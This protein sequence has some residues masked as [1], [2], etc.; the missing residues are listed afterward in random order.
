MMPRYNKT[1]TAIAFFVINFLYLMF[2]DLNE[3]AIKIL[4]HQTIAVNCFALCLWW[5]EKCAKWT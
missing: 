1:W 5:Q 4:V 3:E 2:F